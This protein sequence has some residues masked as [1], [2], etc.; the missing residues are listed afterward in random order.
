MNSRTLS[1][2]YAPTLED[3]AAYLE[4]HG[5]LPA[6][7]VLRQVAEKHGIEPVR[8]KVASQKRALA[9]A[10]GEA[11]WLLLHRTKL[12]YP[13]IGR[14]LGGRHHATVMSMVRAHVK[15]LDDPVKPA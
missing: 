14:L 7:E 13:Q 12:S 6:D 8:L 3:R 9:H 11:A 4:E 15:R 5:R 2:K 1:R 10:R